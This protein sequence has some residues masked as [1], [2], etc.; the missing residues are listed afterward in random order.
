[1]SPYPHVLYPNNH[2]TGKQLTCHREYTLLESFTCKLGGHFVLLKCYEAGQGQLFITA[3]IYEFSALISCLVDENLRAAIVRNGDPI[4]EGP[5]SFDGNAGQLMPH[6]RDRLQLWPKKGAMSTGFF[7]VES[8]INNRQ[9]SMKQLD[10]SHLNRIQTQGF[11]LSVLVTG[12]AGRTLL[13]RIRIFNSIPHIITLK[14]STATRVLR[15]CVYEPRKRHSMELRISPFL[16][17]ATLGSGN[18]DA[19][20]WYTALSKRLRVSWKGVPSLILDTAVCRV[21]K[22]VQGRRVVLSLHAIDEY[23]LQLRLTDTQVR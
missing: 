6:I 5:I 22:R 23:S 21:I 4:L 16:R 20:D 8:A 14:S 15:V 7:D 17:S 19:K 2:H 9:N 3:F 11:K 13:K 1:M 10:K 18:D 12:G